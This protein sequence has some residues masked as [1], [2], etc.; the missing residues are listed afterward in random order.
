MCKEILALA[1]QSGDFDLSMITAKA[2]K[3]AKPAGDET[4]FKTQEED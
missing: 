1:S 2:W 4:P 3:L